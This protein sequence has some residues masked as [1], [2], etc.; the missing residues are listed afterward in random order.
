MSTELQ[1]LAD[2][3]VPAPPAPEVPTE[4]LGRLE[5]R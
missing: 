1:P 3:L 5:F 4:A 2:A